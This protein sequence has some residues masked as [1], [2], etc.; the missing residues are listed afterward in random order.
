MTT[1]VQITRINPERIVVV[2]EQ[3]RQNS[4]PDAAIKE[5]YAKDCQSCG[6]CCSYFSYNPRGIPVEDGPLI[7]EPKYVK[8]DPI[9]VTWEYPDGQILHTHNDYFMRNTILADGW[10]RCVALEGTFGMEVSCSVYDKRPDTCRTFEPGSDA[11]VKARKWAG[12][13]HNG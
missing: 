2:V 8:Q 6:A 13:E 9:I 5:D 1:L 12:F 7:C 4:Q 11:C 10:K 3:G